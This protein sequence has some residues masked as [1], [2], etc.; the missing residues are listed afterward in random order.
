VFRTR[1]IVVLI[2]VAC[3]VGLGVQASAAPADVT[4]KDTANDA[5]ES[6][7]QQ[8]TQLRVM[9]GYPDG[10]FRPGQSVTE[11]EFAKMLDRLLVACPTMQDSDFQ[12]KTP[13]R[14]LSRVRA[15]AAIVRCMA[16]K[17]SLDSLT[18]TDETLAS[19][20]DAKSIPGWA[21]KYVAFA[22]DSGYIES[23][24][25]F[26]PEDAITRSELARV[27]AH[28]LPVTLQRPVV[29]G[30]AVNTDEDLPVVTQ[31]KSSAKF[32]GLVVDCRGLGL[33]R[34]MSPF[35]V[36]V[37]GARVYP[38]PKHL[39]SIDYIEDVGIASYVSDVSTAKRAGANP[40]LVKAIRVEGP[41]HQT[42]VVADADSGLIL[43]AEEDGHFLKEYQVTFLIDGK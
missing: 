4:F 39:P 42:A 17:A 2:A 36:S 29:A 35:I 28:C 3:V 1:T 12:S 30:V 5:N 20:S 21:A 15:I 9:Q 13:E 26:R 27:V 18:E 23:G 24:K 40:L 41:A 16:G 11:A 25:K 33:L 34:C 38:D 8:V 31:P 32:T 10:A 7:I 22:V 6:A 14:R 19:F 43:A 37:T